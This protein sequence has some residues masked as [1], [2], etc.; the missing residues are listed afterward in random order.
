MTQDQDRSFTGD[1]R[2]FAVDKFVSDQVAQHGDAE[3][4]KLL[5]DPDQLV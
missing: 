5:N 1:A 2:D 4:G 3:L